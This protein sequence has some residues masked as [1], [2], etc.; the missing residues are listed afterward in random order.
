MRKKTNATW[1]YEYWYGIQPE[2]QKK[3]LW[4]LIASLAV[5]M[6]SFIALILI[7]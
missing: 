5:I 7:S 2:P 4:Y 6:A 1:E 3:H